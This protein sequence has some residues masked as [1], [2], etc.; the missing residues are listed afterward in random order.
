[1]K[2]WYILK[3]Q[4]K[5]GPYSYED[6]ISMKQNKQL[7]DFDYVWKMGFKV[8]MPVALV[9]DLSLNRFLQWLSESPKNSSHLLQRKTK[10]I[11]HTTPVNIHNNISLWK[12][13]TDSISI[14][15][16]L[17]TMNNP[18]ILPGQD[19]HIHFESARPTDIAFSVT[20]EIVGKKYS[21][22]RL[23]YSSPLQY[24]VRFTHKDAGAEFQIQEWIDEKKENISNG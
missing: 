16:A 2:D 7:Y 19:V 10:R 8:W 14:N 13:H 17:V 12:G 20:G 3:A 24:I 1:V 6:M 18:F 22:Q 11:L 23:K 9:D 5:F 15:G 21:T 4:Q